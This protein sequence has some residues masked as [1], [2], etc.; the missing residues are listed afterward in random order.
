MIGGLLWAVFGVFEMLEP[1]GAAKTY[2]ES[3]G[4]ELVTRP[5]LFQLYQLPGAL[6]LTLLP[7]ALVGL[8]SRLG[9]AYPGR[10][11]LAFVVVGLA[12]VS[13]V[14]TVI[15]L[16]PMSILG[17]SLGRLLLGVT[18]LLAALQA[19]RPPSQMG[20]GAGL[21][22]LGLTGIFLLALQPLTW[23]LMWFPPGLSA[24][25]MVAFGFGWLLVG[26]R[27]E[28]KVGSAASVRRAAANARR[29]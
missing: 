3:L 4:Y 25:V 17:V 13:L 6:A 9:L 12:L 2:V 5:L 24:A 29:S 18:T 15:L 28:G 16:A 8:T 19:L 23:A 26:V 22:L 20:W 11:G 14:G 21:L 27:L 10:R 1:F 7:L